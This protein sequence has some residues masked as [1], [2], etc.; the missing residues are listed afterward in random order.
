MIN[1]L[2]NEEVRIEPTNMCN[3]HCTMCPRE[4]HK[5]KQGIMSMEL[6]KSIIEQIVI[7]GAKKLVLTNF[8]EPFVDPTLEEKIKIAKENNLNTYVISNAS[9]FHRKSSYDKS[10][11]KIQAAI[12]NGLD[13]LRLSFYGK[14]KYDYKKIM[15]G[16]N[17]ERVLENI[18]LLQKHKGNC[19]VS[20]YILEFNE[21]ENVDS[22]PQVIKD[23]VD[24]YEIWKPHN[25]GDAYDYRKLN[26]TKKK[27]CGRPQTG[28]LQINWSGIVVPCCYDYD[29]KIVLGDV[30]K[31]SVLDVLN[32]DDYNALRK[33]H[34]EN[35]YKDFSY[36]DNC[37]QLLYNKNKTAIV[38]SNNPI[39]K[40]MNKTDIVN[41]TNTNPSKELIHK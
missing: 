39:H 14:N 18:K 25:W 11:T 31:Q 33:A 36:C 20:H 27:S 38:Y 23:A 19:E 8:G 22:Y 9:L 10:K 13:E 30:S 12:D 41:R 24:Y 34:T 7:L 17:F 32:S 1:K 3:Y 37:D 40:G 6:Y 26:I 35:N 29:E 28:P 5:R 16:G 2:Q 15:V 4:L 21:K